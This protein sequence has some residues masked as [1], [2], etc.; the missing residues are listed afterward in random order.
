MS[1]VKAIYIR[2]TFKEFL[3]REDLNADPG[4]SWFYGNQ[5]LPSDAYDGAESF[6]EPAEMK[7]LQTRW[8]L[9]KKLGRK[10]DNIDLK[11]WEGRKFT[12]VYSNTM[13]DCG[14]GFWKHDPT[15]RPNLRIDHDAQLELQGH[16]VRADI[17]NILWKINPMIDK[18]D[19]LNRIFGEFKPKYYE[20]PKDFDEPWTNKYERK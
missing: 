6:A 17:A 11:N 18:E 8:N 19:E 5:L 7:F 12:S 1:W 10:F 4:S 15:E 2:M 14:D 9:E 13:P 3:L 20:I 16:R